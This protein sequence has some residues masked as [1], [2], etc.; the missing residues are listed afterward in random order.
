[1]TVEG[2]ETTASYKGVR[3]SSSSP[4]YCF[5]GDDEYFVFET[6][7]QAEET[8]ENYLCYEMFLNKI[9]IVNDNTE[10]VVSTIEY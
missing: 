5:L 2:E 9:M 6:V 7:A 4:D 1:M 8:V 10:E 3:Y